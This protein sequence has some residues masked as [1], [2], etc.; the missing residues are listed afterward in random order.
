VLVAVADVQDPT[1]VVWKPLKDVLPDCWMR[2][3]PDEIDAGW[4]D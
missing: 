3:F 1:L 2:A 4:T